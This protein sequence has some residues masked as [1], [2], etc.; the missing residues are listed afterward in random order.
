ML[1]LSRLILR[2]TLAC[3]DRPWPNN[4]SGMS[5]PSSATGSSNTARYFE[6][7]FGHLPHIIRKNRTSVAA[8]TA[9]IDPKRGIGEG[10]VPVLSA[11]AAA[12]SASSI[13]RGLRP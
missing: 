8:W 4:G 13:F 1:N 5:M 11:S 6:H 7:Y 12:T 9:R 10:P 3:V 2:P